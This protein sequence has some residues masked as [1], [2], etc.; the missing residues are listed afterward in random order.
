M[1][2]NSAKAYPV[3]YVARACH[4]C[5]FQDQNFRVLFLETTIGIPITNKIIGPAAAVTLKMVRDSLSVVCKFQPSR[6]LPT[7]VVL[8][9][10]SPMDLMRGRI[11]ELIT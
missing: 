6:V 1:A 8:V 7:Y 9:V 4:D 11:T 2:A 5:P 3:A 10:L